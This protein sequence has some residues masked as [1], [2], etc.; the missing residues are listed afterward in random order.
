ME[1]ATGSVDSV[2]GFDEAR[3]RALES[4]T[5]EQPWDSTLFQ[6]K[7]SS[8]GRPWQGLN[9]W[10]QVG[11]AGDIYIPPHVAHCIL[12]RRSTTTEL[13]QRH[14][15]KTESCHW[16]PGEVVIVPANLPSFWRS[17]VDRDNVHIEIDP[18]WLQ[19]AAGGKVALQSCFGRSD[20]VLASF[21][22]VLLASLDTNTSL[23]P[24]FA[25]SMAMAI[26]VHLVENYSTLVENKEGPGPLLSRRQM[27]IV[28]EAVAA[29]PSEKWTIARLAELV[30]LSPFHFSRAFKASFGST[31]HAYVSARRMEAAT[32]LFRN[33]RKSIGEIARATGYAS[34]AH[35]SEAFRR[36][37]GVTPATYRKNH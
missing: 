15:V 9:V 7:R 20:A 33:L 36:H 28:I 37:W 27:N 6:V 32:K 29:D 31:P 23:S 4:Q 5:L 21:A 17:N 18:A 34:S 1:L 26:S 24:S 25:E 12:V 3:W 16:N 11:P 13:V 2:R 10:H 8:E 30:D 19:R 14:G 35:F 22:Q